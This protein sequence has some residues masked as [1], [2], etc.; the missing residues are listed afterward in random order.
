MKNRRRV[1]LAPNVVKDTPKSQRM[2]IGML[3]E[4]MKARGLSQADLHDMTGYSPPYISQMLSGH[5]R[6]SYQSWDKLLEC[7]YSDFNGL[8]NYGR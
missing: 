5:R 8:A 3:V 4:G 1:P 7:V 2:L 6:G